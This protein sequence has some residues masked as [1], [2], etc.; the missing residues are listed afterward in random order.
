MGNEKRERQKA[1]RQARRA[2]EVAAEARARRIKAARNIAIFVVIVVIVAFALAGCGKSS[3]KGG[4]S[5]TKAT[6]PPAQGATRTLDHATAPLDCIDTAKRYTA[7]LTTTEGKV[8]VALDTKRTPKT[9]SNFVALS[10]WKYYDGTSLFR[11]ERQTGI[12]Q[13]GSP[14]TQS[15]ADPGPG[16]NIPDEGGKFTGADYGPGTLA[17]GRRSGPDGAGAQFFFLANDGGRYLGDPA[18]VGPDAGSYV[19][20]GKVTKGLDVLQKIAA[21][22]DGNRVPSKPVKVTSVRIVEA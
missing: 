21:L 14:H 2:E 16:Y 8:T 20:F 5:A 1:G 18:Q 10:R 22:D 4:S 12:I 3:D 11:T 6:C 13:G 7:E 15:A 19:A 9:T 17:M